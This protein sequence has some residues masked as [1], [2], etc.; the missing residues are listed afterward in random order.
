MSPPTKTVPLLLADSEAA[1]TLE[2]KVVAPV[3]TR[4]SDP[5]RVVPPTAPVSVTLPLPVLIVRFLAPFTVPENST[6]PLSVVD[7]AVALPSVAL[8][9]YVCPPRVVITPVLISVV[10]VTVSACRPVML[11]SV[12]LALPRTAL[13]VIVRA[14]LP[15]PLTV[16]PV[17][18]CVPVRL[19]L[20]PTF[21]AVL[22]TWVVAV[23]TFASSVAE[24]AGRVDAALIANEPTWMV[25]VALARPVVLTPSAPSMASEP[26][27]V[28]KVTFPVPEPSVRDAGVAL[29]SPSSRPTKL[30][31]P[32]AEP[33][34]TLPVTTTGVAKLI[35]L[36]VVV[37]SPA[38]LLDPAPVW[39]KPPA[40]IRSPSA[41]VV[42][43]PALTTVIA[44]ALESAPLMVSALPVNE[45]AP[46]RV[47]VPENSDVPVPADC[48]KPAAAT[49]PEKVTLLAEDTATLLSA[50]VVPTLPPKLILPVPAVML[51]LRAALS[52]FNVL[53]KVIEPLPTP[54]VIVRS[55][56]VST[57]GP[58]KLTFPPEVAL[59]P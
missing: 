44:A 56:L 3:L 11:S 41:L 27:L 19:I 35:L 6:V 36:A 21:S 51:R 28:L 8:P 17:V 54:V 59:V 15:P 23:V 58:V 20:A 42:N 47:V 12:S 18:I 4:V 9:V 43:V 7:R 13:P 39:L 26:T 52:L 29:P 30:M 55:E 16:P 45:N 37:M 10:P 34:A 31:L 24:P 14:K 32:L 1:L 49:F 46:P 22:Y 38:I 50:A 53:P 57:T 5:R 40:A 2:P 48:T 33:I 25:S